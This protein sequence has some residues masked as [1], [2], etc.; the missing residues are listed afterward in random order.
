MWGNILFCT[1]G[2]QMVTY[3]CLFSKHE[4]IR[5]LP[6]FKGLFTYKSRQRVGV[7]AYIYTLQTTYSI[8]PSCSPRAFS[9]MMAL[10]LISQRSLIQGATHDCAAVSLIHRAVCPPRTEASPTC[11]SVLPLTL[12]QSSINTFSSS[13]PELSLVSF[14]SFPV[15]FPV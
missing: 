1:C 5:W 2:R 3:L 13:F 9:L 10:H 8:H 11:H 4:K 7:L 15:F 12:K 14:T 6:Y